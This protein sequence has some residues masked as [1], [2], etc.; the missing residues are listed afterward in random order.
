MATFRCERCRSRRSAH[1]TNGL[2]LACTRFATARLATTNPQREIGAAGPQASASGA[3][4]D[5]LKRYRQQQGLSQAKLAELLHLDQS[6]V[7]RLETGRRQITS[8]RELR[9]IARRLGISPGEFGVNDTIKAQASLDGFDPRHAL[10]VIRQ[11]RRRR[12]RGETLEASTDLAT[13][14]PSVRVWALEHPDDESRMVRTELLFTRS[15]I[16]ADLLPEDE[17]PEAAK[18]MSQ[19]WRLTDRTTID[20]PGAYLLSNLGNQLRR[21]GQLEVAVPVLE[22]ALAEQREPDD[23]VGTA[24]LLAKA[25]STLRRSDNFSRSIRLARQHLD[26][27]EAGSALIN[28]FALCE[29]EARGLLQLNK[30]ARAVQVLNSR[31]GSSELLA[32]PQWRIIFTITR[33]EALL[34]TDADFDQAAELLTDAARAA[35]ALHLPHQLQRIIRICRRYLDHHPGLQA[36]VNAASRGLTAIKR[37]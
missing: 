20:L 7:S 12:T 17:L 9:S 3:V 19:A 31:D 15:L 21:S 4:G 24:L 18:A 23:I 34:Q 16:L 27:C 11:A 32:V 13:V 36:A 33:A 26:S 1:A 22:R 14:E 6:Y 28:D 29:I 8:I 37:V 5:V 30:P 35:Q 25:T 10:S 2:C